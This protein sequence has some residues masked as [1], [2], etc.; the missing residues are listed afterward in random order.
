[1][2]ADGWPPPPPPLRNPHLRPKH[3]RP[4]LRLGFHS[5]NVPPPPPC[6][7]LIA[8]FPAAGFSGIEDPRVEKT[9]L[10]GGIFPINGPPPQGWAPSLRLACARPKAPLYTPPL[11]LKSFFHDFFHKT[12]TLLLLTSRPR[13]AV[14]HSSI[15]DF[16]PPGGPSSAPLPLAV[17]VSAPVHLRRRLKSVGLSHRHRLRTHR[18][19]PAPPLARGLFFLR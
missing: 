8:E 3:R 16:G 11:T 5:R 6:F 15:P 9:T 1:M 2:S 12:Q 13:P 17:L 4:F 19:K 10:P 18:N 7:H 14:F